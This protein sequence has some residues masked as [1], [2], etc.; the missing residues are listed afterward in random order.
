MKPKG[1]NKMVK[2]ILK[3]FVVIF[4]IGTV[5]EVIGLA[6]TF[7]AK[8]EP[9]NPYDKSFEVIIE[10]HLS[11]IDHIVKT[12]PSNK[13]LQETITLNNFAYKDYNYKKLK[14]DFNEDAQDESLIDKYQFY[15]KDN[16]YIFYIK[17]FPNNVVKVSFPL[18][19]LKYY[20]Y[21]R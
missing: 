12:S 15:D 8:P 3:F 19:S 16:N 21:E 2:K 7:I 17:T 18:G 20:K 11:E 5:F 6:Y 9:S 14:G 4:I 1:V 13:D 10:N